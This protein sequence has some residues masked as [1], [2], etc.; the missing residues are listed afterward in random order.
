MGGRGEFLEM[1]GA[2]A[3]MVSREEAIGET[4]TVGNGQGSFTRG[5][6]EN[7]AVMME[8]FEDV[9]SEGGKEVQTREGLEDAAN[10]TG[11]WVW[12]GLQYQMP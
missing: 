12:P 6:L 4:V 2:T 8:K 11:N 9:S 5:V 7:F 1:E 3:R 10:T